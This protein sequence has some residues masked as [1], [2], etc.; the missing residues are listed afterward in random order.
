[1]VTGNNVQSWYGGVSKNILRL[2]HMCCMT[3]TSKQYLTLFIHLHPQFTTF[4]CHSRKHVRM[5][6]NDSM[7]QMI[8]A[9]ISL[10]SN[11]LSKNT[12]EVTS[13]H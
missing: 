13:G 5:C 3:L 1:M 12:K 10:E 6:N 9:Q 7:S 2:L 8:V 4:T 11:M